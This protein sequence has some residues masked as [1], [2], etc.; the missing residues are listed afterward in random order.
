MLPADGRTRI[1]DRAPGRV[2]VS[3]TGRSVSF[4]LSERGSAS[5]T[6]PSL[7]TVPG[8]R[9]AMAR[10]NSSSV[11]TGTSSTLTITS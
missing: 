8:S 9:A 5:R 4:T 7:A 11:P 10:I 2:R 6:R 1:G 3:G